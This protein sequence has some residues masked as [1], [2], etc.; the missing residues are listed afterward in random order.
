MRSTRN[1]PF[2][3]QEKKILRLFR[4][5]F[6]GNTLVKYIT[7]YTALTEMDSDFNGKNISYYTQTISSYSGLPR[8]WISSVGL[9]ML[10][11]MQIV[12]LEEEERNEG[13]FTR[14][15]LVF[16]PEC[17]S[18]EQPM[19][20]PTDT[21]K[22]DTGETN[23]G[24]SDTGN[25][26]HKKIIDLEDN[27]I[28]EYNNMSERKNTKI[29]ESVE[30]KIKSISLMM[31]DLQKSIGKEDESLKTLFEGAMLSNPLYPSWFELF[32]ILYPKNN[33]SKMA[34]FKTIER[35]NNIK[36]SIF[37]PVSENN[38]SRF[39]SLIPFL[40]SVYLFRKTREFENYKFTKHAQT[41]LNNFGWEDAIEKEFKK[42]QEPSG[43]KVI[44]E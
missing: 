22:T 7:L 1:Q 13:K 33:G 34:A 39:G 6:K 24:F 9:K 37:K 38:K 36:N 29:F 21:R 41:W 2:C 3:W 43:F 28:E 16:T 11:K 30:E 32:W 27:K 20:V 26:T 18:E 15:Y 25:L 4:K 17:V 31:E 12:K 8:D 23:I 19:N 14:K 44:G 35:N 40:K 5:T 10:I 42:Q